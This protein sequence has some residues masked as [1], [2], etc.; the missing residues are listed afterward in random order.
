ME[1]LTGRKF[2]RWAV[3]RLHPERSG[4]NVMWLCRCECG[5]ER[6]VAKCSLV[7]GKSTSCGCYNSECSKKRFTTHSKS[8]TTLYRIY[9]S[10][11]RRCYDEGCPQFCDYG[12]RGIEVC[13]RW[14]TGFEAF[15]A[16][17]GDR[18]EDKSLDRIDNDGP[19]SPENCRWATRSEQANNRRDSKWVEYRGKTQT[20][21]QWANELTLDYDLVK[22]RINRGWT[23]DEAFTLPLH[24]RP[25]SSRSRSR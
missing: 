7:Y 13:E 5:V 18:P 8:K 15:Y 25:L 19:Y 16:D 17:M 1:D 3:I 6:A 14:R 24:S 4:H 20:L 11:L 22:Y 10:M 12:G 9:T 23:P 21:R 2:G